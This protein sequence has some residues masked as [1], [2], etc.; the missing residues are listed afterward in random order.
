VKC[1]EVQVELDS[2]VREDLDRKVA[3]AVR[4]HVAGCESCSAELEA[5]TAMARGLAALPPEPVDADAFAEKVLARARRGASGRRPAVPGGGNRLGLAAIALALVAGGAAVVVTVRTPPPEPVPVTATPPATPPVAPP[6]P[7]PPPAA[8]PAPAEP[9]V[10]PTPPPETAPV[11]SAPPE[12][13]GDLT[14][15]PTP[16]SEPPATPAPTPPELAGPVAP[17][18]VWTVSRGD[19]RVH[20]AG[21]AATAWEPLALGG[22]LRP[23]DQAQ[24][25]QGAL[26][27]TL[28]SAAPAPDAAGV[29]GFDRLLLGPG[30]RATLAPGEKTAARVDA[31]EVFASSAAP[32]VLAVGST[33]ISAEGDLGLALAKGGAL[34]VVAYAGRA[35]VENGAQRLDLKEGQRVS[36][37]KAGKVGRIAAAPAEAPRWLVAQ[38]A[39]DPS[40]VL[41]AFKAASAADPGPRLLVG[42][43]DGGSIRGK[44]PPGKP[45]RTK[46]VCVGRGEPAGI[47][48]YEPGL[49]LRVRYRLGTAA[50]LGLQLVD[51]THA[52]NFQAVVAAPRV[53]LWTEVDFD[54]DRLVDEERSGRTLGAGDRLDLVTISA[55]GEDASLV[56][57]VSDVVIYRSR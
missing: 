35:R 22:A 49:R 57:E 32:L 7:A 8:A 10:E 25:Q 11:P 45:E 48:T 5:V 56:L 18:P 1:A 44:T 6:A 33:T 21:S 4:A 52:R 47:A 12:T 53:G 19:A 23:G 30:S 39:L 37:D 14:R 26:E 3:S 34:D 17:A 55:H 31:G 27:L 38:R 46:A 42:D 36:V 28:A 51:M 13:P 43:R 24:A 15:G 40:R 9:P 16:P 29:L 41:A 20:R 2:Y 54:L 50:P